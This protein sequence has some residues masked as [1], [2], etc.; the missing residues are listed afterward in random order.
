MALSGPPLAPTGGEELGEEA[1]APIS[2]PK[3][4]RVA[5]EVVGA[6][7]R[8]IRN[9]ALVLLICGCPEIGLDDLEYFLQNWRD[10]PHINFGALLEAKDKFGE[11]ILEVVVSDSALALKIPQRNKMFDDDSVRLL[12]WLRLTPQKLFDLF[13]RDSDLVDAQIAGAEAYL[14]TLKVGPGGNSIYVRVLEKAITNFRNF[15]HIYF[16]STI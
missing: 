14:K 4:H 9:D 11:P 5:E 16:Q 10:Y 7:S 15:T 13:D 3:F 1:S 2:T 12:L 6:V 8:V